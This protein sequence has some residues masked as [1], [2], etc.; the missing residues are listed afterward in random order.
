MSMYFASPFASA[1]FERK[2]LATAVNKLGGK[3]ESQKSVKG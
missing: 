2:S 1:K 3:K